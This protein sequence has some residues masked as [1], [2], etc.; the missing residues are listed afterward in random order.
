MPKA[1]LLCKEPFHGPFTFWEGIPVGKD[2]LPDTFRHGDV[3]VTVVLGMPDI[4]LHRG[5]HD[6]TAAQMAEFVQPH[7]RSI[8]DRDGEFYFRFV[9][10]IQKTLY[11]G[12]GRDIW[13]ISIEGPERDLCLIPVLMEDIKLKTLQIRNDHVDST[14]RKAPPRL[15]EVQKIPHVLVRSQFR[16]NLDTVKI[17]KVRLD[18][19]S[20]NA[21]S[22]LGELAGAKHLN[23]NRKIVHD[24]ISF[25]MKVYGNYYKEG[26]G[27]IKK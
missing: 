5:T 8:E 9:S 24:K 1:S 26:G 14:V 11:L 13:Q 23:K 7:A 3:A 4:D 22:I 21:D 10:R 18:I 27:R 15:D 16:G 2:H 20:I 6:I 25:V 19:S 12:R 17:S